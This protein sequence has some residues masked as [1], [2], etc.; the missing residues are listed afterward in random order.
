M[1]LLSWTHAS[2]VG[3]KAMDDQHGI[4]MDA[5]NELRLTLMNGNGHGHTGTQ[6]EQLIDFTR[7][8]FQS[9]ERLLEQQ[10][11]PG[12][13]AHRAAHQRF[14]TQIRQAVDRAGRGEETG[15]VPLISRLRALYLEHIEEFDRPYGQ[16]LNE[17]GVY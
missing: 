10:N 17:R 12:L 6:L 4:L 8:H 7:K 13:P 16:W 9:E 3:V 15:S 11:F 2:T 14:L 5:M 1:A